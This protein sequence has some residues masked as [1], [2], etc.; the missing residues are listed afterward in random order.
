MG[1]KNTAQGSVPVVYFSVLVPNLLLIT[2]ALYDM[3]SNI[4]KEMLSFIPHP[5]RKHYYFTFDGDVF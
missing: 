1:G 2:V 4:V 5:W 3:E